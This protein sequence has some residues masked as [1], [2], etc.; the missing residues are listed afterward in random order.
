MKINN[1]RA[2]ISNL[3]VRQQSFVTKR[4]TWLKAEKEIDW[5]PTI[6]DK[7]F[8]NQKNLEISRQDV[9]DTTSSMRELILKTIYWGYTRGMRGNHFVNILKT[10]PTIENVLEYI[11]NKNNP[12]TNDFKDLAKT[13]KSIPG[14]GLSTY[15]K[16]LYFLE[17]RFNDNPCLILDKKL[18]DVFAAKTY[19]DFSTLGQ[20]N[21]NNAENKYLY[22][23]EIANKLSIDLKTKGEN[24]EQFLFLFGNKLK[25][26]RSV[27]HKI[28]HQWDGYCPES[29]INGKSVRMRLNSWDFFESEETRLQICVLR[30][31][32]AIILNFRGKG[33]FR[34]TVSYG[35]EIEN[36]EILSPQNTDRP[37]FNNPTKVFEESEEIENYI[38][39]INL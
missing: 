29:L 1:Y 2:L 36:G 17:I 9:F 21:Y 14:L 35:D 15:S 19:D 38:Q 30:G 25:L 12:S 6:N 32:Q 27:K 37:P 31:V 20:I 34:S 18:I 24:I 22:Y 39:S 10:I 33:K 7:I 5:L 3:P 23:L 16:L 26:D 11:K 13:L 28:S 8:G 4:S